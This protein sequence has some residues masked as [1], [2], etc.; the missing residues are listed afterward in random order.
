MKNIK[1][2]LIIFA[3]SFIAFGCNLDLTPSTSIVKEDAFKTPADA[4]KFFNGLT[5]RYRACF[6]G[7]NSYTI[8]VQS[9][10][11]N[12]SLDYGNRNGAPHRMDGSFTSSDYN[13]ENVWIDAYNTILNINNFLENIDKVEVKNNNEQEVINEYKGCAYLYRASI[14]H[15][16]VRR[17]AKVYDKANASK[18][19]G[20]PIVIVVDLKEKPAR[21]TI[22]EVY[23]QIAE[24]I[25]LAKELLKG[26]AGVAGA[27]TPTIDAVKA[28][29]ARVAL[30]KQDYVTAATI[31]S[32]LIN[33]GKY[34]LA[35][36]EEDMIN[37]WQMDSGK[38]AILQL[39]IDKQET[40][41]RNNIYL[42][43]S[44]TIKKYIPDFIPTKT[45]LEL[46]E[47]NDLRKQV[48]FKEEISQF[49]ATDYKLILFNKYAGN[50]DYETEPNREYYQRP[51]IFRIGEIYLINAEANFMSNKADL[52]K[53]S[54]NALQTKRGATPTEATKDNIIKEWKREI[55]GEGYILDCYKR[56][57][58]GFNGRTPQNE[59]TIAQG[60]MNVKLSPTDTKI[61]WAIPASERKV[62]PNLVGNW[63]N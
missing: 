27:N 42:G 17:Y 28:L 44:T 45:T 55:I 60:S 1:D 5:S 39:Y 26:V 7:E 37:E 61:V 56:W 33:S 20:V 47:D 41:Q 38:E 6:Y 23:T 46:Y 30:Y 40:S 9:E 12:A 21:K 10:Y 52:A 50:P 13:L 24:D 18:D 29:E 51:K 36:T 54:L 2:I 59:H 53:V 49:S 11:F 25:K 63:E 8:E 14:Y 58:Q 4:E 15:D 57:G 19:L 48:W 34:T 35:T 32:E 31:S 62:N 16:L 3:I 43:Y 22:E